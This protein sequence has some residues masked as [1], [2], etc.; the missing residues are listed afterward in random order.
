MKTRFARLLTAAAALT[1]AAPFAGAE[2]IIWDDSGS[3]YQIN[4][5]AFY[6]QGLINGNDPTVWVE[7]GGDLRLEG[8]T[9]GSTARG[10]I[11]ISDGARVDALTVVFGKETWNGYEAGTGTANVEYGALLRA[12]YLT[13]GENGEGTLVVLKSEVTSVY[14]TIIGLGQFGVGNVTVN[15]YDGSASS[16]NAANL[17]A[18]QYG[19]AYIDVLNG[20]AITATNDITIG[21]KSGTYGV[22]QIR[23]RSS[24][25]AA[26]RLVIGDGYRQRLLHFISDRLFH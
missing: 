25:T 9:I 6:N 1:A 10:T 7:A 3:P 12:G 11:S 24:L 22:V 18:G 2:D 26:N 16:L 13:I 17:T 19:A 8:L 5:S 20:G 21:Q 4:G 14:D 15:G 23:E